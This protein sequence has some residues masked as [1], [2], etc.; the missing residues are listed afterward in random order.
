MSEM[1]AEVKEVF[2][3]IGGDN[4]KFLTT[5]KEDA[6]LL[7]NYQFHLL[8]RIHG[9]IEMSRDKSDGNYYTLIIG[10]FVDGFESGYCTD[11]FP[12]SQ[13]SRVGDYPFDI[14]GYAKYSKPGVAHSIQFKL[15]VKKTAQW[16]RSRDYNLWASP[17]YYYKVAP[18]VE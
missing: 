3:T 10:V 17:I 4:Q 16:S 8:R 6:P 13:E 9:I 1:V 11:W 7:D 5:T 18:K 14:P 15:G 2:F 12:N